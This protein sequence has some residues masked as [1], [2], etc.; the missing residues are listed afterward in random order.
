MEMEEDF[1]NEV[2]RDA[3]KRYIDEFYDDDEMI[4]WSIKT[5]TLGEGN[6]FVTLTV[7]DVANGSYGDIFYMLGEGRHL[8]ET[9]TTALLPTTSQYRYA[10]SED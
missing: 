7:A 5:D 10:T 8:P 3:Y 1:E 6:H 4:V 2:F 9:Q